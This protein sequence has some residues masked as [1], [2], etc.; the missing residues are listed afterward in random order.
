MHSFVSIKIVEI[1]AFLMV[2]GRQ[3]SDNLLNDIS[4][5]FQ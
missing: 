4:Y 2:A 5:T 1:D 3:F